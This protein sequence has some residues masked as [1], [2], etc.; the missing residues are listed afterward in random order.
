MEPHN[1]KIALHLLPVLRPH[2]MR[3]SSVASPLRMQ[4]S[5]IRLLI[6][7]DYPVI[8]HGLRQI[9][10]GAA[11]IHIVAE[12]R[13]AVDSIKQIAVSRPDAV[14]MD[15]AGKV[16]YRLFLQLQKHHGH[17]PILVFSAAHD[18]YA[19]K[20]FQRG[21]MGYVTKHHAPDHLVLA[22][23]RISRGEKYVWQGVP[24]LRREAGSIATA[25][26]ASIVKVWN[27]LL[28]F[29]SDRSSLHG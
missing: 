21:A 19:K 28:L 22:I 20:A 1:E 25:W 16:S 17:L 24:G 14:L 7:S 26:L 18:R 6:V 9:F 8:R 11:D 12:A 29:Q 10:G 15:F 13:G 2:L 23:R 27:P 3:P 4:S 5:V